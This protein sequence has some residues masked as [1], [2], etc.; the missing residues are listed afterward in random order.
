MSNKT[1][2]ITTLA[3]TRKKLRLL[4]APNTNFPDHAR[5]FLYLY[6]PSNDPLESSIRFR[7]TPSND[8]R[9]F[10]HGKD[11]IRNAGK[12]WT[13]TM[14]SILRSVSPHFRDY[15][16]HDGVLTN[17]LITRWQRSQKFPSP[18]RRPSDKLVLSTLKPDELLPSDFV[19]MSRRCALVI[20]FAGIPNDHHGRTQLTYYVDP[21]NKRFP[22]H[23]RGFLYYHQPSNLLPIAASIRFRCTPSNDP[24]TFELGE[25]LLSPDGLPW[26]VPIPTILYVKSYQ[27]REYLLRAGI[28]TE[29]QVLQWKRVLNGKL[30]HR[31]HA[32][33]RLDQ[34]FIV[35]FHCW[36]PRLVAVVGNYRGP[37]G[38]DS[39]FCER[40]NAQRRYPYRGSLL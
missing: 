36:G 29:D 40:W 9:T 6:Q 38:L 19:D 31:H 37:V 20:S 34:P 23:A 21:N 18:N 5:G 11:L 28:V 16:L 13:I 24:A 22:D 26:Q 33:Y 10:D 14:T 7:C 17:D 2:Q 15:L 4:F 12:P 3:A 30:I 1:A 39:V 8:P 27:M 25:D 35:K 32:L